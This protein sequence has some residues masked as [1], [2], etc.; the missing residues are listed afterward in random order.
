MYVCYTYLSMDFTWE[1]ENGGGLGQCVC[2]CGCECASD[3]WIKVL[4]AWMRAGW[5]GSCL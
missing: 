3:A 5:S 1:M 2:V 4:V